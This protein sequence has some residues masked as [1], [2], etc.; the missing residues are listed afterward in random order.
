[1]SNDA[2]VALLCVFLFSSDLSLDCCKIYSPVSIVCPQ[3]EQAGIHSAKC[4]TNN[5]NVTIRHDQAA[6]MA[7]PGSKLRT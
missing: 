6:E 5:T 4:R 7:T 3:Q 2:H 1:M